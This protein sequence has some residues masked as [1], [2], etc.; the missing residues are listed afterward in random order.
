MVT[1]SRKGSNPLIKSSVGARSEPTR[2][3]GKTIVICPREG[4]Q[5]R[6][7]EEW[8]HADCIKHTGGAHIVRDVQGWRWVGIDPKSDRFRSALRG[9]VES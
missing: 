2:P 1:L 4:R 6:V 5:E 8:M 3:L 7:P 9:N